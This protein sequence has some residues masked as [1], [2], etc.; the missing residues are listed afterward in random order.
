MEEFVNLIVKTYG[1]FGLI[2][3]APVVAMVWLW[4]DNV[5]LNNE[6]RK[7][8]ESYADRV[9]A[10]GQRVVAAQEKRVDDSHQI[11]EQ[12]VEMIGEHTGAQKETNLAL[13]RIGDMVSDMMRN[14]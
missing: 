10:L 6:M 1:L 4:R 9:D 7:M 3:V 5:R 2:L 11:A 8:A 14:R 12:L 13:D